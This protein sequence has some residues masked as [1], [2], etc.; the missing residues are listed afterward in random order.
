MEL[1]QTHFDFHVPTRPYSPIDA[2]NRRAIAI[3]SP[4]V[5]MLGHNA[6]YNGH[7]VTVGWNEYRQYY[8]AQYYFAERVILAR[9][10]P[11]RCI[12]AA[13]A[14][15]DRGALGASVAIELRVD[16]VA[17][18]RRFPQLVEGTEPRCPQ[19]LTWK[20]DTAARCARDS[21]NHSG[22]TLIF[23]WTLLDAAESE[24][25]YLLALRAKHG[26]VFQ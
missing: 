12:V 25:S 6:N 8:V 4:R 2:L 10:E 19:W 13:L 15:Y 20:H 18:G 11:E 16:D 14:E 5:A 1:Q 22:P 23:D 26:R 24:D 7:H 9:G 21:A 3:G 17:I